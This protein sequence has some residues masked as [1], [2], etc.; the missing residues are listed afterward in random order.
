MTEVIIAGI[1]Q[2]EVGEHRIGPRY[3]VTAAIILI[4]SITLVGCTATPT[5]PTLA[6]SF[7]SGQAFLDANGNGQID[8]ED[9]PVANAT[10]I[11]T[12]Q[13]GGEFGGQTDDTGKAFITI[14]AS[15][16]YPVTVR[17]E[18]PK[19]SALILLEPSTLTLSEQTSETVKFLFSSK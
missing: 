14:P 18:A 4:L 15:V 9:T 5:E 7:F 1:G 19:D 12:L 8:S 2:T 11:V 6:D 13:N 17:M 16:E 3:L 10:F